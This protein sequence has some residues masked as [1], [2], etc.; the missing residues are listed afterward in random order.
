MIMIKESQRKYVVIIIS[1]TYRTEFR[2]QSM[3]ITFLT[4]FN[5]WRKQVLW[6][7]KIIEQQMIEL[8]IAIRLKEDIKKT[9][10]WQKYNIVMIQ[11]AKDSDVILK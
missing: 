8:D 10:L 9:E 2:Y 3:I 5:Y 7:S 4:Y 6:R 1:A 11:K